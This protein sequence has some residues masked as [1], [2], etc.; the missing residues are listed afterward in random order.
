MSSSNDIRCAERDDLHQLAE[1]LCHVSSDPRSQCLHS[2]SGEDPRA[3][4]ERLTGYMEDSE[5]QYLLLEQSGELIGA[6]GAE[7]DTSLRRA[8]LHGPHVLL[9][10]WDRTADRLMQHL[11]I[12]LP[13]EVDHLTVYVNTQNTRAR[14]F[15]A[16]RGF[17]ERDTASHEFWLTP[18]WKRGAVH[19]CVVDLGPEH[20]DS[21]RSLYASLFPAAYYSAVRVIEM[22]G[23]SH[24][25]VVAAKGS[26]V[27]GFAVAAAEVPAALGEVQFL[28]VRE[29]CRGRGLGKD[30]LQSAVDWLSHEA[31][32][33]R[34][35]LNVDADLNMA[36]E[37]YESVGFELRF[38]GIGLGRSR[39][40]GARTER[41]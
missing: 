13:P 32:V 33:S 15:Y 19:G 5:L 16:A 14:S 23:R 25:V 12:L 35:S 1:W 11:L 37:L 22:I 27:L 10:D 2:W 20:R 40:Q 36:R 3:L 7:Y 29:D 8:W 28:G 38:S 34:I 24:H 21:F 17:T 26:E 31:R 6:M 9:D 39:R 18:P 30:L 4:A 41:L